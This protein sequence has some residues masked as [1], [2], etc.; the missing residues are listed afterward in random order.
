V[1]TLTEEEQRTVQGLGVRSPTSVVPS[2]VNLHSI[3]ETRKRALSKDPEGSRAETPFILYLGRLDPKKQL[4]VLLESFLTVATVDKEIGLTIAG[5]D[6]YGLWAGIKMRVERF[7]LGNRVR[8]MGFVDELTKFGLMS[9]A[10][11]FVQPSR[12]E[13]LS[14]AILEAMACGTP[15]VVSPGCNIPEVESS[16]AGF[17]VPAT[18]GELSRAMMEI[19]ADDSLR[20]SMKRSARRLVESKF[21]AHAMAAAMKRL[22]RESVLHQ[23]RER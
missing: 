5:P 2:G 20:N 23:R 14:M 8:Y 22:Y 4:D 15:V 6:P 9:S 7:G 13:G 1:H 21:T 19:L 11:L 3:D 17:V 10:E 12:T 16:R 18:V